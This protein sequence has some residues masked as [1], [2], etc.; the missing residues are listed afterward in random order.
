MLKKNNKKI[1]II[2]LFTIAII[3]IFLYYYYSTRVKLYW[4]LYDK[5]TY[6]IF[7]YAET[8]ENFDSYL[9]KNIAQMSNRV[10]LNAIMLV[11]IIDI[12]DK[13]V[14]AKV[15]IK[16][17]EMK[18][19]NSYLERNLPQTPFI[20]V[21]EKNGNI[22]E[23]IHSKH[24][25]PSVNEK[26]ESILYNARFV[27]KNNSKKWLSTEKDNLGVYT[28]EYYIDKNR[29][30]KRR[31]SQYI[32]FNE[33]LL[34]FAVT[35]SDIK[36]CNMT[37]T[38]PENK[39]SWFEKIKNE[40]NI[41]I[42]KK[43]NVL[44]KV[45]SATELVKIPNDYSDTF[46]N[47]NTNF[48]LMFAYLN[49][50][51]KRYSTDKNKNF[52][53]IKKYNESIEELINNNKNYVEASIA[54]NL[55]FLKNQGANALFFIE[56]LSMTYKKDSQAYKRNIEL[57]IKFL[58]M[59]PEETYNLGSIIKNTK[60][61]Q[62]DIHSDLMMVLE[63]TGHEEAQDVLLSFLEIPSGSFRTLFRASIALLGIKNITENNFKRL[64]AAVD[65][66][67]LKN[68]NVD[69]VVANNA[70][71]AIGVLTNSAIN[72][73]VKDI[74]KNYIKSQFQKIENTDDIKNVVL[75]QTAGN[76]GDPD[77]IND[78]EKYIHSS[79]SYVKTEAINS[80]RIMPAEKVDPI[81]IKI[82]QENDA[83]NF[84]TTAK[85]FD[86][87]RKEISK[88]ISEVLKTKYD[89]LDNES[90][91]YAVKCLAKD[92]DNFKYLADLSNRKDI[93]PR[94]KGEIFNALPLPPNQ[95]IGIK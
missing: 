93:H 21:F 66:G 60:L 94:V 28:A 33:K 27:F 3:S 35:T 25:I 69:E 6:K 68:F 55:K 22:R 20:V 11:E 95:I 79:H 58:N 89:A 78:I 26:F 64:I 32:N 39:N 54:D 87:N 43:K 53:D 90:K 31:I 56:Q 80:L 7:G 13:T 61:L 52:E 65:S 9:N 88:N 34:P 77:F 44:F 57:L 15:L 76:T 38:L 82:F 49:R 59:Y 12:T 5:L 47:T 42:Y 70:L 84:I 85:M 18:T 91:I 45:N 74:G 4:N 17:Y 71:L 73:N 67:N 72:P 8:F 14:T 46:W 36:N 75:I 30:I 81:I 37:I 92:K 29:N 83:D 50:D 40:I 41:I 51:F 23:F 48:D 2:I 62:D 86:K 10:F 19:V 24:S 63:R 16:N 1:F